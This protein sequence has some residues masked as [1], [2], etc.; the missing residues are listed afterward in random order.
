MAVQSDDGGADEGGASDV[1][2]QTA[3]ATGAEKV[4][5]PV[6]NIESSVENFVLPVDPGPDVGFNPSQW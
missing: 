6:S 4:P 5:A 2:D 3:A 1:Q